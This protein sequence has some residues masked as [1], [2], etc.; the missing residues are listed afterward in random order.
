MTSAEVILDSVNAE[1]GDRITTL[2]VT[3]PR[4]VLAELTTHRIVFID[5]THDAM[6][7]LGAY[8]ADIPSVLTKNSTSSRAV[9]VS[10]MIERVSM[11]PFIPRFRQGKR[12]MGSGEALDKETQDYLEN[13]WD[14]AFN[15]QL[16]FVKTLLDYGVEKGQ[17]N[18][19]LEPFSY[20]EVL[21]TAT[22]W[23]NFMMLRD[24]PSAQVEIRQVARAIKIAMDDS[25][26]QILQPGEWHLP[27]VERVNPLYPREAAKIS[28][29]R[30]ARISYN[31]F[32]TN[33]PS[34]IE[35]DFALF[36]KL[37]GSNPRHLAPLEPPSQAQA[38]RTRHGN[39]VGFKSL[40]KIMFEAEESGG[41]LR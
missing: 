15:N 18:R 22:E 24:H 30:C 7:V 26:P 20:I 1:T 37:T 17:A 19:Y 14:M 35:E 11:N 40:R 10:K 12:G 25:E 21:F 13:Q 28:A 9:P 41:D 27:Y 36:E 2:K 39:F 4:I 29:A 5:D 32:D 23:K 38:D 16:N 31:S 6:K 34:T 33:K 8:D 3:L